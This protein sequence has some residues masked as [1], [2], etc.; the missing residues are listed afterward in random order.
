MMLALYGSLLAPLITL[1]VLSSTF[2][3]GVLGATSPEPRQ[4]AAA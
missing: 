1:F 3:V 2:A 4:L